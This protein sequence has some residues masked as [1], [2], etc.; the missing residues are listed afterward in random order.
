MSKIRVMERSIL[1]ELLQW[2]EA[3]NRKPLI[4]QGARQVG[5]TWIMT[6]FGQTY[7]KNVVYINF[8]QNT[9]LQHKD[10][11]GRSIAQGIFTDNVYSQ[12]ITLPQVASGIYQIKIESAGKWY[13]NKLKIE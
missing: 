8:E 7:F 2:K 6:Y 3:K 9:R 12:E 5:K 1:T 10:M 13:V 11:T 4:V